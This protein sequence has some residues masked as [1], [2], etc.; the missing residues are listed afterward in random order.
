MQEG[1]QTADGDMGESKNTM[2]SKGKN[3]EIIHK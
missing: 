3:H 1:T 2:F